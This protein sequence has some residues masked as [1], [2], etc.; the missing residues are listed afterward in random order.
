MKLSLP[1]VL[2]S[3]I[4]VV[5]LAT[6][7]QKKSPQP[8]ATATPSDAATPKPAVIELVE[9]A[10]RSAHFE[11]VARHL[12]LGGTLFGYMDVD[13]DALKLADSLKQIVTRVAVVQPQ[14]KPY[15]EKDFGAIVNTLGFTDIK[16]VG[17]SS[18]PDGTGYFRN[19]VFLY[20]PSPRRGLLA[21]LGGAPAAFQRLNWAAADTDIYCES[22]IDLPAVYK[23]VFQVVNQVGG[24]E[25]S[26]KF[27]RSLADAG[28][29]AAF[30]ALKLIQNWKG[31]MVMIG[32]FDGDKTFSF[33]AA[34]PV[35]IPAFSLLIAIDGV[36]PAVRDALDKLPMFE[37]TET[38]GRRIYTPRQPLPVS[39][40]SPVLAIDGSTLL[41]ATTPE[42]LN[43][44]LGG[45]GGLAQ[46][47]AFQA[48]LAHVGAKGNELTYCTPRLFSR[49]R[50]LPSLNP[51]LPVQQK[52]ILQ[53]ALAN[54]PQLKQGLVS[55]RS[56]LPDGI[57]IDSYSNAS[58]KKNLVL[59]TA[60]NPMTVGL[61]AAMAIPAF[62]KV[63]ASS[64]E[65][66]VLNNLRQLSA[67]ADQYYLE[68]GTVTAKYDDLVGPDKYIRQLQAIGGEDYRTLVFRQGAALHIVVPTLRKTV[69]YGP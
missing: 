54:L 39:G 12:E 7:C 16:A 60:Y 64:Q 10:E 41:F 68:T 52:D 28:R 43:A 55:V 29:S 20:A 42:Y 24:A 6:G 49:L 15:A 2:L 26:G 19:R 4:A 44:C 48:A 31:R 45:Q 67:A 65:K 63:R 23:T 61:M 5:A 46:N 58:L 11:A 38:G 21:G 47:P 22:E 3:G 34:Q 66:T 51:N 69:H 36:A 33:P 37:A 62:Q 32:R 50:D 1:L 27:E 56:N 14:L 30:S 59:L 40:L 25:A 18:V 9:P 35:I 13:G 8:A 57:L 53:M 17:L